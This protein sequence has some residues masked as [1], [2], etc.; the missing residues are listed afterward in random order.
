MTANVETM[1]YLGKTP[2]HNLG[3]VLQSRMAAVDAMPLAGLDWTVKLE[4]AYAQIGNDFMPIPNTRVVVRVNADGSMRDPLATVGDRYQ[5]LQ[6]QQMA[7][8]CDALSRAS[9]GRAYVETLGSLDGGRKVWFLLKHNGDSG[10]KLAGDDSSIDKYLLCCSS[11]DGTFQ[12]EMRLTGV[13]IVCSNTLSAARLE[14]GASNVIKV[15]H[16]RTAEQR[17]D[18]AIKAIGSVDSYFDGFT[19]LADSM[20]RTK[21]TKD[22][23]ASIVKVLAPAKDETDVPTATTNRRDKMMELLEN[24]PGAQ[25]GTAW[26]AWMALTD[27]ADHHS[28]TRGTGD[29]AGALAERRAVQ[30]LTTA[31]V[32]KQNALDLIVEATKNVWGTLELNAI[33]DKTRGNGFLLQDIIDATANQ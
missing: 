12:L 31:A 7:E 22:S 1:A 8:W 10:I 19:K 14:N 2:W 17:M 25:P 11:H 18:Q 30:S 5:E 28:L 32:F 26:G 4:Q 16:T 9:E 23:F 21:M 13:R 15:R 20:T 24:T 6:N 33:A 3:T 27:Y 29:D